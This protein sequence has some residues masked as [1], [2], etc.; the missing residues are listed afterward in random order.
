MT[1]STACSICDSG[2]HGED[3]FLCDGC[4]GVFHRQCLNLPFSS[5]TEGD[6]FCSLYAS[7]DSDVSSVV[8]V[9]G[10]EGF[11]PEQ[12]KRSMSE[13]HAFLNE[14]NMR[15]LG[16]SNICFKNIKNIKNINFKYQ[17][18]RSKREQIEIK[19]II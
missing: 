9:E 12:R 3:L 10:C 11:I 8:D 13:S 16:R 17:I 19:N 15:V 2:F 18:Y 14:K 1:R 5:V 6:W 4:D 7:Y